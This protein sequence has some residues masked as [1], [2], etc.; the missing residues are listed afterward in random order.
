MGQ[1]IILNIKPESSYP[2]TGELER[3]LQLQLFCLFVH[4]F[5]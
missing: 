2:G 1:A 3:N 4:L 5:F